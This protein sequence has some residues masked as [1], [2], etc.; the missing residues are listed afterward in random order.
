MGEENVGKTFA[1]FFAG[2][3]LMRMGL[4][5]Q[6]WN[7][8]WANDI[9]GEKYAMYKAHFADTDEHFVVGDV[10]NVTDLDMKKELAK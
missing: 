8:S 2:I 9:D 5:R 7:I 4:E 10:H 6:G 3:G 1:E